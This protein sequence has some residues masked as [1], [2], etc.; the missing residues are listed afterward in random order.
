[1]ST[2]E[3]KEVSSQQPACDQN[4]N[5]TPAR[6]G[7][8]RWLAGCVIVAGQEWATGVDRGCQQEGEEQSNNNE[9]GRR[10]E[11]WHP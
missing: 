11:Q 3:A 1:V 5:R 7:K 9:A 10:A 8:R 4:P 6:K 2:G